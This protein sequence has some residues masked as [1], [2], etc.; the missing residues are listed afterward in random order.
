MLVRRASTHISITLTTS[1]LG[2]STFKMMI[3]LSL[4][5]LRIRDG[6]KIFK[7]INEHRFFIL[8]ICFVS[9]TNKIHV[10]ASSTKTFLPIFITSCKK[11]FFLIKFIKV[12]STDFRCNVWLIRCFLLSHFGPIHTFKE[13]VTLNLLGT[14]SSKS[15]F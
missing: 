13:R 5:L 1:I 15:N 6:I 11:W 10:K 14:I 9:V 2:L 3:L 8:Y 4:L 7:N 12:L